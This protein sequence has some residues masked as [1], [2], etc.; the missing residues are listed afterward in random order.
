MLEESR[1]GSPTRLPRNGL[2]SVSARL[3]LRSRSNKHGH[4]LELACEKEGGIAIDASG[5]PPMSCGKTCDGAYLRQSERIAR[6]GCSSRT[7]VLK[8]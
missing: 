5:C 2:N 3:E 8:R 4:I 1:S 6:V 7:V